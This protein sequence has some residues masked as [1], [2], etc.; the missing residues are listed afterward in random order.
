MEP[1]TVHGAMAHAE[2]E[3]GQVGEQALEAE[4]RQQRLCTLLCLVQPV[5][6]GAREEGQGQHDSHPPQDSSAR[7]PGTAL[8]A[9]LNRRRGQGVGLNPTA[10]GS[11]GKI[12]HTV[13]QTQPRSPKVPRQVPEGDSLLSAL[14]LALTAGH[15][16]LHPLTL[17]HQLDPERG[18]PSL[19]PH[20]IPLRSQ[21]QG[22]ELP[23]TEALVLQKLLCGRREEQSL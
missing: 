6:E 22:Q 19:H 9:Q 14:E 8:G 4:G 20:P 13:S 3:G 5:G 2:A 18:H 23:V 7:D 21:Q 10:W 15:S 12:R 11:S 16:D 1:P 17:Q